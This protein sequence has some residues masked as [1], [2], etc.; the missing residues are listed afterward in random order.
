MSTFQLVSE[1]Q[2]K[3]DQPQAIGQLVEGIFR[4]DAHQVLLGV[5]GSGK[6]FTM[7]NVIAAANRPTLVIA[8]NKTLVAQ[9]YGEFKHLFP[10]NSVEYFVS[11]YDYYQPEAYV[12]ASDTFIEKD[13]SI[14]EEIERMRHAATHALRTRR[15]VIVVASV[16]CIYA[17]GTARVYVDMAIQLKLGEAFGRNALMRRLVECQYSRSDVDFHRG[18]FR[19]RGDS[20]EVFP[21]YE[22]ERAIRIEFFG[23][24]IE[25]IVEYDP[26]R[27]T[28]FSELERI[29][30]FPG[31]HYVTDD[32]QRRQAIVSIRE[33]LRE[34]LAE[35]TAQQQLLEA[36]RLQQRTS[37]DLEMLEQLGFC[38][39]IENYSRHLSGRPTGEAPPCLIDYFPSDL[40][41]FVDESHQTIP[42]IGAMYKGDKS[43]KETL[44]QYGFRLPSA[45]DNRP[46]KFSEYTRLVPQSIYVSAT[47][48]PWELE[49]A[50]G[51][52]VEQIIRPTGLLDPRVEVRPAKNQV[53][54][55]LEEIRLRVQKNERVLITTLTK[56]MAED[57]T[58]FLADA[59]I[60][61][62]YL[63]SDIETIE[64]TRIIR[65]L[66]TG[67]FDVLVGINLLR[68]GLDMPEV[69]LVAIL[70]ADK[71]G[72]LRS[73]VSLIQTIGRAAR[74]VNGFVL[75][76]ADK[77]TD[78][79]QKA[80][81]ETERRRKLQSEFNLQHGIKPLSTKRNVSDLSQYIE[82][83]GAVGAPAPMVEGEGMPPGEI[84]REMGQTQKRM[85]QFAEDMDFEK[86]A[87]ERDK[88]TLLKEM[89]L[90]LKPP[91][92]SLL[93][94]VEQRNPF[95]E[96][97]K[98]GKARMR[99]R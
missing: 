11:Y 66:R 87:I 68:E 28:L 77:V 43:R 23:E 79:M 54:D 53:D 96:K 75:M 2:P 76:Y 81:D 55:V 50:Q 60:R 27:G 67:I 1:Y 21:A 94:W 9:L 88:L 38:N 92:R 46:L 13:A 14:N 89:D 48:A 3:G 49:Q 51:V 85:L 6:T 8:H 84:Q 65:E 29:T 70:D 26:L 82:G 41:V 31:S 34:R 73:H 33:E 63:H 40:L 24:G 59:G 30:I 62:R 37:Y 7:A 74:N 58:E 12:P 25:R 5:T 39:G 72:F 45:L 86:A 97:A 35:L 57:L 17:M 90:G 69:S 98:R 19:V 44:V 18:T 10:K 95:A 83:E 64:R 36:Q 61:V 91:L 4:N 15:D 16:S 52:V 93:L 80:M 20:I 56:R 71:E 22:E 78:S 47:P 42:Q 99:R 32:T